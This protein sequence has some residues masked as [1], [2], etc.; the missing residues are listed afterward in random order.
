MTD[1]SIFRIYRD[2]LDAEGLIEVLQKHRISFDRS[3]EK[4][5]DADDYI[6]SNP[7]DAEI[8]IRIPKKDFTRTNKLI[9]AC[10]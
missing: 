4:P 10:N 9:N 8:V 3:F 2:P 6:G 5:S 1:L 7:H